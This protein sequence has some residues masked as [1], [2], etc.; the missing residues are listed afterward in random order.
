M[1]LTP[2]QR[3]EAM[4]LLTDIAQTETLL[5]QARSR[6]GDIRYRLNAMIWPVKDLDDIDR[7]HGIPTCRHET[8]IGDYCQY[9][10]E[11]PEG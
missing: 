10:A 8:P 9:C 5:L 11:T 7:G 6:I 2:E 1:E 4:Q 3:E